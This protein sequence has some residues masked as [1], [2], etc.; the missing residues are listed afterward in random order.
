M[1]ESCYH[2]VMSL[3]NQRSSTY[4]VLSGPPALCFCQGRSSC[5]LEGGFS[6]YKVDLSLA[7][8]CC[9]L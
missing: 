1:I 9:F 3:S 7:N 6:L 5:D 8:F 4:T 2:V